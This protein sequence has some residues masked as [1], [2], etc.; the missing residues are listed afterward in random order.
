MFRAYQYRAMYRFGSARQIRRWN[1]FVGN[2]LVMR[3]QITDVCSFNMTMTVYE[4][5]EHA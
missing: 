1:N 5:I 4:Y 3:Y 2:T